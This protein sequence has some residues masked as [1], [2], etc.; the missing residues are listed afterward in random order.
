MRIVPDSPC[1][2]S[3]A[4]YLAPYILT[5]TVL[6]ILELTL[7]S[8]ASRPT[9]SVYPRFD[10][11]VKRVSTAR[12]RTTA[13]SSMARLRQANGVQVAEN[14]PL[15]RA[16]RSSRITLADSGSGRGR[17]MRGQNESYRC[18]LS[19]A[20]LQPKANNIAKDSP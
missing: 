8:T 5:A 17:L 9:Q 14:A 6:A 7:L 12:S 4:C 11:H 18:S 20:W 15:L 16:A 19:I 1:V 13:Y 10:T 2:P 3:W